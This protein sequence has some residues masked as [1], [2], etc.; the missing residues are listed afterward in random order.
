MGRTGGVIHLIHLYKNMSLLSCLCVS[1]K[2]D[3]SASSRR[4]WKNEKEKI[5]SSQRTDDD[6]DPPK[7]GRQRFF[8]QVLIIATDAK[9]KN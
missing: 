8:T 2:D 5:E 9:E 6:G 3:P 4:W 7:F 1:Y